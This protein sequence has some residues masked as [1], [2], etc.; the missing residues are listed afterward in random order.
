MHSFFRPAASIHA[1]ARRPALPMAA[2]ALLLA[3][4]AALRP[5]AAAAEER[6]YLGKAEIEASFSGRSIESRNIASG[7]L[8]HWDFHADGTVNAV[9]LN[10]LGRAAGTWTIREDGQTCVR[11]LGRTGCRYW[12][13]QGDAYA[14]AES[15]LPDAPVIAE[16]RYH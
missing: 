9:S 16:V 8:S 13:R 7:K 15:R 3:L 2:A 14:N 12:F 1:G 5:G 11:L 6:V 4:S 10:G